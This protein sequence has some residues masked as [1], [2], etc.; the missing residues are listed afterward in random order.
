MGNL[1][2]PQEKSLWKPHSSAEGG[3]P[4]LRAAGLN[5]VI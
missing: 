4:R 5:R 2:G 3:V 1:M